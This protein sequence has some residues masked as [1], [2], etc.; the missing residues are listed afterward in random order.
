MFFILKLLHCPR[1]A[2]PLCS[3]LSSRCWG[4]GVYYTPFVCSEEKL[5]IK[6]FIDHT[7]LQTRKVPEGPVG[8]SL[9]LFKLHFESMG[10]ENKKS[11]SSHSRENHYYL[12]DTYIRTDTHTQVRALLQILDYPGYGPFGTLFL[13]NNPTMYI[14]FP[15]WHMCSDNMTFNV[16]RILHHADRLT[17]LY[18]RLL[19]LALEPVRLLH[20]F[21]IISYT[22]E[23]KSTHIEY[24]SFFF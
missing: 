19:F 13:F 4:A 24:Q 14:Y 15:N 2:H 22:V 21:T 18:A 8:E 12:I 7:D 6:A 16:C 20:F 10:I 3:P 17:L 1:S 9:L 5:R 23:Y 11:P